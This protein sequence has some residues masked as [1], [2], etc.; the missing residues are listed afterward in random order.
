M[1]DILKEVIK[2]QLGTEMITQAS[3]G[4][5]EIGILKGLI[6]E[7]DIITIGPECLGAHTPEEKMNLV[8]FLKMY[9]VLK[10]ILKKL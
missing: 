3:H 7:L 5:L 10:A 2:E 1:R 8:S 6:P 9:E 4:G